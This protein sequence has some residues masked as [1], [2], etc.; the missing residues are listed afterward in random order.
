MIPC[1]AE[2]MGGWVYTSE[3][4]VGVAIEEGR[5]SPIEDLVSLDEKVKLAEAAGPL[6]VD[7]CVEETL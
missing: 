2:F 4:R 5:Q 3:N 1:L 7:Q 6:E